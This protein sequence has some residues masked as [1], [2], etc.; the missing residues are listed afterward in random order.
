MSMLVVSVRHVRMAVPEFGMPMRM[1]VRPI[2][3]LVVQV[4][5][6]AVVMAVGMFVHQ[7]LVP[8]LVFMGLG[9]MKHHAGHHQ[10][11]PCQ[12]PEAS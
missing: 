6:V 2:G 1:A 3:H 10:P 12:R 7:F 8:M 4:V 9:K 5:V 11:R